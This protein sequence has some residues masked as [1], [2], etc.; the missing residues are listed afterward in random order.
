MSKYN[1]DDILADLEAEAEKT[2]EDTF[3]SS[4]TEET[5]DVSEEKVAKA[6]EDVKAEEETTKEKTAEDAEE[7]VEE[8]TEEK[9]AEEESTEE[10]AEEKVAEK[11]ET[12]ST[13]EPAEEK[14]AEAKE[15]S[16][17]KIKATTEKVA[18]T[19]AIPSDVELVKMAQE[20]GRIAAHS[21]FTELAALG[22]AMP[23][24]GEMAVPPISQVSRPQESPVTVAR[25]AAEQEEAGHAPYDKSKAHVPD[26]AGGY[27]KQEKKASLVSE[28][29]VK[30]IYNKIYSEEEN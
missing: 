7:A 4:L 2:A 18:E 9:T 20:F 11:S 21:L 1:V 26:G 13:E 15:E 6:T 17:D 10:K 24:N 12:D 8:S 25:D 23:T 30:K 3:L 22:I 16:K 19:Q 28:D 5:E 27:V 14:T 29:L